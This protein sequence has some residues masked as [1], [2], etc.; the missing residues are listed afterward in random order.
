MPPFPFSLVE[1]LGEYQIVER[2]HACERAAQRAFERALFDG[3]REF[4]VQGYCAACRKVTALKVDLLWG[5]GVTPNWRERLE[6]ACGLIN[7]TR[8]ALDF[9]D[10]TTEGNADARIYATEQVTALYS[11]LRTLHPGAVGSEFLRDGTAPGAVNG[12]G[13]RH[14]DLTSLT[15]PDASFDVVL[16]FDVLEHVPRYQRALEETARILAPGGRLIASFPFD[17]SLPSTRVRA[18]IRDD[19]SVEHHLPPEYHGDPVADGGCLCFQVFGWD[20]LADLR[21]AGF[22]QAGVA[23]YWSAERGYLG[24]NQLLV[25]A[26]R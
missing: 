6:C 12:A 19:G 4:T 26:S 2:D 1:S 13:L 17:T 16:S 21:A 9:L 10:G 3:R 18:S 25:I 8:A 7:R 20:V 5:D 11:H 24:P 14:E 22:R 15:F 23:F